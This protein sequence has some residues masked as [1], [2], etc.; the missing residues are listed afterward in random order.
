MSDLY[1]NIHTLCEKE[2]I[3]D[4]TLE[5]DPS[6]MEKRKILIDAMMECSSYEIDALLYILYG[7]H[8]QTT[9]AC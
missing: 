3:K 4:G 2:G 8:G 5:D 6:D 7:D 1:S 9:S